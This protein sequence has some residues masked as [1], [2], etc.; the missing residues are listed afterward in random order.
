MQHA[1][2]NLEETW[3]LG[4]H[5][6]LVDVTERGRLFS[7]V[8]EQHLQLAARHRE[9]VGVRFMQVP[10][11]Y[12]ARVSCALV[13]VSWCVESGRFNPWQTPELGDIPAPI[14]HGGKVAQY[15]AVDAWG[16]ERRL[17]RIVDRAKPSRRHITCVH[18]CD[19]PC[20]YG[21]ALIVHNLAIVDRCDDFRCQDAFV[22]WLEDVFTENGQICERPRS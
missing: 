3:S 8:D 11:L 9:L 10:A 15:D 2:R 7:N 13:A 16:S 17:D 4:P 22:R 12:D 6:D 20:L 5:I 18:V 1:R 21:D 19:Y 14:N